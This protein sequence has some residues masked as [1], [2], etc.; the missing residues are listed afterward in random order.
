[1]RPDYP[2][3]RDLIQ[4]GARAYQRER[5]LPN[6]VEREAYY[7]RDPE[8]QDA[9]AV[10]ITEANIKALEAQLRIHQSHAVA[11]GWAYN[12]CLH[13]H[14]ESCLEGEKA[15]LARQEAARTEAA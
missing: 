9:A 1:M 6:A 3:N 13:R 14:V 4:D 11:G 12:P 8:I 10:S 2:I 7:L 15:I 5:H